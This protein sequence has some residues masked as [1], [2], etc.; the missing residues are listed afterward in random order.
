MKSSK[1]PSLLAAHK[2]VLLL[3]ILKYVP[4][5]PPKD[6][7]NGVVIIEADSEEAVDKLIAEEVQEDEDFS[8]KRGEKAL[9][10]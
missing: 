10:G 6:E 3:K 1:Y 8:L 2:S 9:G 7:E 5:P 4:P